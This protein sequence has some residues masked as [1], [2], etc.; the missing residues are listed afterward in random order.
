MDS[1][2]SVAIEISHLSFSY[3]THLVL[4]DISLSVHTG[5]YYLIIGPNGGGKTTLI[6]LILGLL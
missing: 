4:D 1:G 2:T 6:R 3:G 5:D